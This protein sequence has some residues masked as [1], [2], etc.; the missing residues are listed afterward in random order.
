MEKKSGV[1]EQNFTEGKAIRYL[2]SRCKIEFHDLGFLKTKGSNS[3]EI[4]NAVLK[5]H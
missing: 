1:Y 3:I 2:C 4:L 5:S